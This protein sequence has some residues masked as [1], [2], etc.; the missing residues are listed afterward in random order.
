[1][2]YLAIATK[3]ASLDLEDCMERLDIAKASGDI[4]KIIP[5]LLDFLHAAQIPVYNLPSFADY[6][7]FVGLFNSYAKTLGRYREKELVYLSKT[8]WKAIIKLLS[9]PHELSIY[10]KFIHG[11]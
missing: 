3:H 2:S 8:Y 5:V 6:H 9:R 11:H 1:M 7:T 10:K 4:L